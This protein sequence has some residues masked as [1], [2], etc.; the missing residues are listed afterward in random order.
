MHRLRLLGIIGVFLALTAPARGVPLTAEQ[1][2]LDPDTIPP[3]EYVYGAL[4][5]G[6]TMNFS[7]VTALQVLPPLMPGSNEYYFVPCTDYTGDITGTNGSI[8]FNRAG[9]YH[10]RAT[11]TDESQQLLPVGIDLREHHRGI[12]GITTSVWHSLPTPDGGDCVV[13]DPEF[14]EPGSTYGGDPDIQDGFTTWEQVENHL[15]TLT[16]AHVELDGHGAPG[17]FKFNG[18]VVLEAGTEAKSNWLDSM[19]GHISHLSFISCSVAQSCS[20][21]SEA[22]EKL[23]TSSGYT[24]VIRDTPSS[25]EWFINADGYLKIVPEP[26]TMLGLFL[27]ISSVSVYLRRRLAGRQGAA[28]RS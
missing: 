20:L 12:G 11:F 19:K 8:T 17:K 22:A 10:V 14:A 15:K 24:D 3:A 27:A 1:M 2:Y 18:E 25:G 7:N 28:E 6:G 13:V 21:V 4:D 16:N 5:V 23:G 9:P 26:A